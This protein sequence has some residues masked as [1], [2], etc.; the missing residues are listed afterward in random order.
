MFNMK[1]SSSLL[2]KYLIILS[3]LFPHLVSA[4]EPA[5]IEVILS[6]DNSIY[7]QSLYGIQS[8]IER[9][10]KIS[11]LDIIN[12][13][14]SSIESYFQNLENSGVPLVITIG[15]QATKVAKENL[16]KTP[17][18]FS[19]VNNP[20]TLELGQKNLCGVSMDI[21][22]EE[23]FQ[24]LKDIDPNIQNV[25]GFYS[26]DDTKFTA[27]EGAFLDLRY[28]LLYNS[29]QVKADEFSTKLKSLDEK[30]QAFYMISDPLYNQARFEELSKYS[31]E[32]G[33]ILMT[34][35][36]TLVRVGAT[37]A[38]SPEYS[39]IG[40]ETGS[41]ANRI[42]NKESTCIDER[43]VLP[44]Q[45]A[46]YL[47][48]DYAR[49]S[50]IELPQQILERAKLTK[51]FAAGIALLNE[52][53]LKSARKVF[54]VILKKDPDNKAA[55]TYQSLVIEKMTG[56]RTR[57]LL[58]NARKYYAASQYSYARA[59]YQ[60]VLAINPNND[61]AREGYKKSVLAQSEQERSRGNQLARSGKPFDAI[62][63]YLSSLRTLSSN[64]KASADLAAIRRSESTKI[65][66]YLKEG[67]AQYNER[68][69]DK[70][71]EIFE[72]ILLVD[73]NEKSA[74]E[75]LRLSYKKKDAIKILKN[76]LNN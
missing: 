67:I 47:N 56:T 61:T 42:L 11:Y 24:T 18:V 15:P 40:V 22:V 6:S 63:Q 48:E 54:D 13:E 76:K 71:I 74:K 41:M 35:F 1:K 49:E 43:V 39:K 69:Y 29:K 14:Y 68:N 25:V 73:P 32:N 36:P 62:K 5:S 46:F 28:K 37:F 64:G 19:M 16:R 58:A 26:S 9:E 70:S 66:N 27:Y 50:G 23:F 3:L 7:E 20:K 2:I 4:D 55:Q 31:K 45:S 72:N 57:E 33:I 17:I 12:S 44:S 59:E 30:T 52:D 8:V 60:K 38:I 51:L 34:S 65:P 10:V 75:Y 21:S 53:K